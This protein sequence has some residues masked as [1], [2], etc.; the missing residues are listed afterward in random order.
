MRKIR[1]D[2]ELLNF[3]KLFYKE[4][5]LKKINSKDIGIRCSK[6]YLKEDMILEAKYHNG[7]GSK[8]EMAYAVSHFAH[9]YF[10]NKYGISI[11]TPHTKGICY[12]FYI[13]DAYR[14]RRTH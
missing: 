4:V 7:L 5:Q 1:R 14:T 2:K 6:P 8:E 9:A 12:V 10:Y 3:F 11:E 13:S